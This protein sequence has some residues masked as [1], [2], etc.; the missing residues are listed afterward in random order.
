MHGA[1][2]RIVKVLPQYLDARGRHML[3]PSL[4]ERDAYQAILNARPELRG[5]FQ[6]A[7]QWKA[8][9]AP[10]TP[11]RLRAELRSVTVGNELVETVI[12]QAARP[13]RRL[14]QWNY[15]RVEGETFKRLGEVRAWRVSLWAGEKLLAEQ[16]SFLW[17]AGRRQD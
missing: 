7:V 8:K 4:F 10:E 6:L 11:L 15:L 1:P 13:R 9:S 5:G 3:S 16:R 2:A 12:E 17:Q 14:S